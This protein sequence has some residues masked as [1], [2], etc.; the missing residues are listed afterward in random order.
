MGGNA[1][2]RLTWLMSCFL[3]LYQVLVVLDLLAKWEVIAYLVVTTSISD[4]LSF[5]DKEIN[6][7]GEFSLDVCDFIDY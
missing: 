5:I 4:E 1:S 2:F 7:D 3:Q 6:A